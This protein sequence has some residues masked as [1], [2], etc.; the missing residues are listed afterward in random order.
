MLSSGDIEHKLQAI[1]ASFSKPSAVKA[2]VALPDLTPTS[3]DKTPMSESSSLITPERF[4]AVLFDLDGVL[5]ATAKIHAACWKEM[6]DEYLQRRSRAREEA[7]RAFD[8]DSDYKPYV[9]GKPRYEGVRSFLQSRGI[10]LPEGDAADPPGRETVCGLGNRKNDLVQQAIAEGKVETYPSSMEL[11]RRL[12]GQGIKTA[13][14][15]SSANCTD[16]LRAVGV[17]ELF[18]A[19]VDGLVAD[20]L[21]LPV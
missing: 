1:I 16:V 20:E 7:F 12:L 2:N 11:V 4:D 3:K 14:V 10:E 9:D 5:T 21:G 18:Q 8:L 15:S 13:V 19:Q 17:T 6:F